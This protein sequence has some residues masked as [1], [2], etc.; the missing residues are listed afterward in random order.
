[1]A[2]TRDISVTFSA[3]GQ[4]KPPLL[5]KKSRRVLNNKGLVTLLR[6]LFKLNQFLDFEI[7]LLE[8]RKCNRHYRRISQ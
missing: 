4:S 6:I 1:M 3:D 5:L 2:V 8:L 7:F